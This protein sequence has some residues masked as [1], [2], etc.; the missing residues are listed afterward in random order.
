MNIGCKGKCKN[1]DMLDVQFS[2]NYF[3]KEKNVELE[4][5]VFQLQKQIEELHRQLKEYEENNKDDMK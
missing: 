1:A 4:D 5:K 2:Q 3:I